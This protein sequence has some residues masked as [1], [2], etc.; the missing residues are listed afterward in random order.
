[1]ATKKVTITLPDE[2]LAQIQEAVA[3]GQA[4]SVSSFIQLAV[5][6]ILDPDAALRM[7][8]DES[9]ARTGGPITAE[10]RAWADRILHQGSRASGTPGVERPGAAA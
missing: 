9:L 4:T 10:E 7:M 6:D 1:M 8:I 2:Q 5:L 3:N